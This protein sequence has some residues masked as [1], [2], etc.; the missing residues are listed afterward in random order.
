MFLVGVSRFRFTCSR[1]FMV[2]GLFQTTSC[3][4]GFHVV[5]R[6][7]D[8]RL[9]CASVRVETLCPTNSFSKL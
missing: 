8:P 2:C 7:R 6:C 4:V 9:H 3:V 1:G 5:R